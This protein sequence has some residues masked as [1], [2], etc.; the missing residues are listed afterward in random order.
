[1]R[2]WRIARMISAPPALG[3]RVDDTTTAREAHRRAVEGRD[4]AMITSFDIG[5]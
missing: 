1:M 2:C 5:R 4:E 3:R